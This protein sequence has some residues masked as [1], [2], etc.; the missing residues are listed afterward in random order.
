MT[1]SRQT[2]ALGVGHGR[3]RPVQRRRLASP[4]TSLG[5]PGGHPAQCPDGSVAR[6]TKLATGQVD[7]PPIPAGQVRARRFLN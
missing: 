7:E 2:I 1:Q 6:S 4:I 5:H 3:Y